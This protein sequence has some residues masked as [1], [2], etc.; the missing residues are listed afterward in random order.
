MNLFKFYLL[1]LSL[2]SVMFVSCGDDEM[3]TTTD[4]GPM[5]DEQTYDN[6]VLIINEGAF[7][8]GT[9]TLDFY[10]RVKDTLLRNVYSTVNDGK[11]IGN[12]LQS[13]IVIGDNAFLIVNNAS[14][15]E[16][17]DALTMEYKNTI[18]GV[19]GPRYMSDLGN[20]NAVVSEW[21]L[22]GVSGQLKLIDLSTLTIT[23]SVS[24][25]GPEQMIIANDKIYV[26]N[27]G[28][29]GE[30]NVVSVHRF[31]LEQQLEITVGKRTID[32]VQDAN[33]DIWVLSGGSY[34]DG[35][36]A[37]LCQIKND[38]SQNCITLGGFPSDLNIDA[39]GVNLYYVEN[40]E[41]RNINVNN[42]TIS[43][44]V[45][46]PNVTGAIYGL[47]YDGNQGALYIG[48][49]PDFSSESTTHVVYENG[50]A[51][52]S[53]TTGVLTNGFVAR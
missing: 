4:P 32:M 13:A 38:I 42:P 27:S 48:T 52:I 1:G 6:G 49:T 23:D 15:I 39:N 8:G 5:I 50:D 25:S 47:G 36:G 9:G 20:G 22:N 28:G 16:V 43:E 31:D 24:V 10:D 2:L 35:D 21:G 46:L 17:V 29:F 34:V 41:I 26:A 3:I 18:S 33:N 37:S 19:F 51:T 12:V 53:F 44:V 30:S 7:T 11:V 45:E 14:K 40:G